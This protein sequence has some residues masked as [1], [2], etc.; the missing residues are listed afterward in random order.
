MMFIT[1]LLAVLAC[2]SAAVRNELVLQGDDK[3]GE[4]VKTRIQYKKASELPAHLDYREKGLLTSDLNQ[5]IPVYCG[6]CWAHAAMSSIA[7]RIKIATN[8]TMRDVIPSIQVLINCGHAGSCNGG[9]SNAANAYVY[10]NGIPDVTCQQYQAKNMECSDINTCMNCDPSTGC[11][12]IKTYPLIKVTEHGS[13][14]GDENIMSEIMARG[15]VSAYINADC[16]ETYTG[17]IQMY[18]NCNTRTT[19]HAIQLNGWGSE[20]GVDFWIGRNSWGTYWGERGF[21]RIVR[22]GAYNPGTV[23]WAVPEIPSF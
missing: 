20:N 17:G 13:V 5:H 23:Y 2:A 11:Y 16:L 18:D 10:R 3:I 8:G 22:G 21:F 9:D 19:N 12:A 1:A 14:K 7:D 4:V 15:P 6:S